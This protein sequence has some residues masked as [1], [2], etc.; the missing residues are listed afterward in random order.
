LIILI[1]RTNHWRS[2]YTSWAFFTSIAVTLTIISITPTKRLRY[3]VL[4][5]STEGLVLSTLTA[6][7]A[8]TLAA[9][10]KQLLIWGP[11][12][13]VLCAGTATVPFVQSNP[14]LSNKHIDEEQPGMDNSNVGG[15]YQN[16]DAERNAEQPDCFVKMLHDSFDWY[17]EHFTSCFNIPFRF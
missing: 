11:M 7:S 3:L 15:I 13:T 6:A 4:L 9:L 12:L 14:G 5:L 8:P 10:P 17:R 1:T 2:L 16:F